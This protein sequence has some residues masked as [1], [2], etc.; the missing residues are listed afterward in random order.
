MHLLDAI[1]PQAPDPGE[2]SPYSL[3]MCRDSHAQACELLR[4]VLNVFECF[5]GV[6]QG[7]HKAS[8]DELCRE[9][10]LAQETAKDSS[11]KTWFLDS[12]K[13]NKYF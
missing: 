12:L 9:V 4:L 8:N 6:E 3:R 11:S 5:L 13:T 1:P 7:E 10:Q 2:L